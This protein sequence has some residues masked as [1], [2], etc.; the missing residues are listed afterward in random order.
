FVFNILPFS[1]RNREH[2]EISKAVFEETGLPC[3]IALD[4]IGESQEMRKQWRETL[5]CAEFAIADLSQIRDACLFE[6]G[7]V[8]GLRKKLFLLAHKSAP[9]IPYGL[10]DAPMIVYQSRA[11]L[12]R[13]VREQCCAEYKRKVYNLDPEL[14]SPSS[15]SKN[16]GGI[17]KWFSNDPDSRTASSKLGLSCWLGSIA[18]ALVLWSALVWAG[19]SDSPATFVGVGLTALFGLG[20]Q[21]REVRQFLEL[22]LIER[23]NKIFGFSVGLAFLAMISLVA[24]YAMRP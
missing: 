11:D 8:L 6:A 18:L 10:D 13:V 5:E 17:P 19:S 20:A 1:L 22:R 14:I 9:S 24:A 3:R 21:T 15:I 23:A 16:G 4:G 2:L 7:V 12:S